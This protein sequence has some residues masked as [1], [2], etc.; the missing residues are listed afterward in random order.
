MVS[1]LVQLAVISSLAAVGTLALDHTRLEASVNKQF[2]SAP[3][4][5][6][7]ACSNHNG[8]LLHWR[9]SLFTACYVAYKA[10]IAGLGRLST[11]IFTN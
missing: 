3:A 4:A 10:I 2:S 6:G 7:H 11:T 8:G 9:I 5:A 1:S